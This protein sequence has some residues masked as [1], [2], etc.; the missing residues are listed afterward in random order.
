MEINR[1]IFLSLRQRLLKN[2]GIYPKDKNGYLY[3]WSEQASAVRKLESALKRQRSRIHT[4]F[5]IWDHTKENGFQIS[6]QK[7][8][9]KG[10]I[11][12]EAVILAAGSKSGTKL[13][14]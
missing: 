13:R 3:P 11:S 7:M 5:A 9:E 12:G 8:G 10:M 2:L 6:F 4:G 1:K 14:E